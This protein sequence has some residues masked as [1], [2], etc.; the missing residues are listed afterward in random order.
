[1]QNPILTGIEVLG[2]IRTC[3]TENHFRF[4]VFMKV[5]IIIL[6]SWLPALYSGVDS[7]D[8]DGQK[9]CLYLTP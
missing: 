5:K 7:Y 9:P 3:E 6:F 4:D 1:M 2:Y 8:S